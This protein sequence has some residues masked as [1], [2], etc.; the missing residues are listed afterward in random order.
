MGEGRPHREAPSLE[1]ASRIGYLAC[2]RGLGG[3]ESSAGQQRQRLGSAGRG[4]RGGS[5]GEACDPGPVGGQMD[6]Q[7]V[8]N[9]TLDE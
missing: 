5:S 2:R 8:R 9:M 1:A 3:K 4:G 7:E 6:M